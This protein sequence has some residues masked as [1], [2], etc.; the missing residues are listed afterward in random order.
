MNRNRDTHTTTQHNISH[1]THNSPRGL[2]RYQALL[3]HPGSTPRDLFEDLVDDKK[4][5]LAKDAESLKKA[6]MVCICVFCMCVYVYVCILSQFYC[7]V[8]NFT[9]SRMLG[10]E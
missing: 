9:W 2:F 6:M 3:G 7:S 8:A 4:E 1:T 5:S 10:T